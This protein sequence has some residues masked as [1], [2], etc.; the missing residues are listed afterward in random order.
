MHG[1]STPGQVLENTVQP[2]A[3]HQPFSWQQV[4]QGLGQDARQSASQR[5]ASTTNSPKLLERGKEEEAEKKR[6]E[7][8]K[9]TEIVAIIYYL[10]M[11]L[12]QVQWRGQ[13]SVHQP[14]AC[15][16]TN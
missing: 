6:R 15:S 13:F 9:A 14:Q 11:H 4:G 3:P 1:G 5:E 2:L 7:N 12:T 16:R 10:Y 8:R